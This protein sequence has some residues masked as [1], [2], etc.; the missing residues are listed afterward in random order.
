MRPTHTMIVSIDDGEFQPVVI[1]VT[2]YTPASGWN[3]GDYEV[4]FGRVL[5]HYSIG[6]YSARIDGEHEIF[7]IR[8]RPYSGEVI[9]FDFKDRGGPLIRIKNQF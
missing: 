7:R 6:Q 3:S 2:H 8:P 4:E 1:P 5:V 9:E